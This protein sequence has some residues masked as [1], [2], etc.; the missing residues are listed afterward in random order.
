MKEQIEKL[1]ISGGVY[2]WKYTD[3]DWNYPG[4]NM[5]VDDLA[6][7]ELSQLLDMMEKCEWSTSKKILTTIPTV[8]EISAP[9]NRNG[10][11]KWIT[12][13][14][15]IL[16]FK[17]NKTLDYWATIETVDELEIGFGFEKLQRFKNSIINIPRGKGDYSIADK[18]NNSSLTFWWRVK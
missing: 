12:E 8:K 16:S 5:T 7:Q 4:W 11:A 2:I 9:N 1:E 15:I 17:T 3:N 13:S 18:D 10:M 6:S 14:K